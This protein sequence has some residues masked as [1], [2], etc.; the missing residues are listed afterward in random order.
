MIFSS[1]VLATFFFLNL[2]SDVSQYSI[3]LANAGN[4][5]GILPINFFVLTIRTSRIGC[6]DNGATVG[7]S[8]LGLYW[9]LSKYPC[10][11]WN[12]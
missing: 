12:W 7:L 11:L 3:Q 10:F 6:L 4:R 8:V 1:L 9:G 2:A 5:D